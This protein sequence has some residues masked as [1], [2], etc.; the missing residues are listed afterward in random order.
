MEQKNL[1]YTHTNIN[2]LLVLLQLVE[3]VFTAG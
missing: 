3:Q 1:T 2:T